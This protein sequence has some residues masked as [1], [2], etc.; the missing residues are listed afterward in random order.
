MR[1]LWS[2]LWVSFLFTRALLPWSYSSHVSWSFVT[3]ATEIPFKS[4]FR[5]L[6][7][8]SGCEFLGCLALLW[9]ICLAWACSRRVSPQMEPE[10]KQQLLHALLCFSGSVVQR[11]EAVDQIFPG[12]QSYHHP[13][14]GSWHHLMCQDNQDFLKLFFLKLK[15]RA[16][17]FPT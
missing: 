1:G 6:S 14:L 10:S 3:V 5:T 16:H 2:W 15:G 7:T 4:L 17:T 12:Y 13:H 8:V 9:M 11:A